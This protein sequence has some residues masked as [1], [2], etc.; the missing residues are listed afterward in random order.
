MTQ[1]M[2]HA[3]DITVHRS[4]VNGHFNLGLKLHSHSARARAFE[5]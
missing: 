2:H 3:C 5:L 4:T 1:Q